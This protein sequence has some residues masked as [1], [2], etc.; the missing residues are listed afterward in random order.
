MTRVT[1]VGSGTAAPQLDTPASGILIETASIGILIDCGPGVIRELMS[2]RDPRGLDAILVGH[3]HADHYIDLIALRY[4]LPWADFT[5]RRI[6]V[7]LPPGGR[8]RMWQLAAAISERVGFFDH[9][10][11]VVEYDPGKAMTIGDLTIQFLPGRHY[12]PSWGFS[13]RDQAGRRVVIS[14][15][16]GPNE[17]LV[18]A[19][20]GAELFIVESTLL[21]SAEDD[22]IRGHLTI[23]E[24][25]DMGARADAGRTV[26]VHHRPENR[27]AIATACLAR[28]R[29]VAGRP[30]LA[31][32]LADLAT[33]AR[34]EAQPGA[35]ADGTPGSAIASSASRA[36]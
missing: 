25:L 4:L 11:A 34:T 10:L 7:L 27:Q 30:G 22:P 24:A 21:T 5:G 13:I 15:D 6:P 9:A 16:T 17:A 14:G 28:A 3:L 12:I 29:A 8:Q 23:G 36:R 31:F 19:A 20:R 1:I 26:L 33:G 2:I 32:D 18:E 35:D